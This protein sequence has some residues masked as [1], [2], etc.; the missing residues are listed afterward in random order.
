MA[1]LFTR[2]STPPSSPTTR[3]PSSRATSTA[4]TAA[5]SAARTPQIPSPRPPPPPVT[6]A[7][8]PS[9]ESATRTNLLASDMVALD[10][11]RQQGPFPATSA[12]DDTQAAES[13][14][15]ALIEAYDSESS[16]T[17]SSSE[18]EIRRDF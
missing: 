6:M 13:Q 12:G 14:Q 4:A 16:I 3:S 5:P 10:P 7:T 2:M 18:K 1:A 15:G 9:R 17:R 8:L 11:A